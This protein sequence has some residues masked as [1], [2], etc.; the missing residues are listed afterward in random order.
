MDPQLHSELTGLRVDVELLVARTEG[1]P[2]AIAGLNARLTVLENERNK[3]KYL[4]AGG[5][6]AVSACWAV[7]Y[8]VFKELLK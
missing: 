1:L 5:A 7:A 3:A 6:S 2:D 4:V 8:F